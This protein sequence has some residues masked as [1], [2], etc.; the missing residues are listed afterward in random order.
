[1]NV[2]ADAGEPKF[3]VKDL[4]RVS[5]A[6]DLILKGVSVDIT[7]ASIMGIIGTSGSGKSTL[8]RALN[9]LWEPPPGS[10]F[11][12]GRDILDLDVLTLRRRVGMLFQL[13]VLFEG[14]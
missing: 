8:L 3:R 2:D 12:D 13:P 1:M 11:L 10:V 4:R 9:R 7:K 5:E 6:G 14:M